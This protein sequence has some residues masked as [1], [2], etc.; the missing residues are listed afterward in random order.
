MNDKV[1]VDVYVPSIDK[2]YNIYLPLFSKFSEIEPLIS[3]A[4]MDLSDGNYNEGN[5]PIICNR[6]TGESL[7]KTKTVYDLKI[8]NGTRLMLL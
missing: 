3:K 4:I 6:E 2:S 1:L 8:D 5:N 7:D